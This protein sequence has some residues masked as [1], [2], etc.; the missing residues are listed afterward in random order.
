MGD[1]APDNTGS[2]PLT[3]PVKF[4]WAAMLSANEKE[5]REEVYCGKHAVVVP[6][7]PS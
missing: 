3:H 1:W 2:D 6:T 4:L 5:T 7:L